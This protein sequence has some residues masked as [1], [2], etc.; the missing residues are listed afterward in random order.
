MDFDI[1]VVALL[2]VD[3]ISVFDSCASYKH[4]RCGICEQ[5]WRSDCVSLW[6][7]EICLFYLM[8]FRK[9]KVYTALMRWKW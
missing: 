6:H 8:N 7:N 4:T 5:F 1:V 2:K 3:A 9:L